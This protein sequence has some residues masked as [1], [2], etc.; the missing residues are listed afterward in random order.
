MRLND[1][2]AI[3]TGAGSGIGRAS[4]IL[5]AEEGARVVAADINQ[6]AGTQTV[7]QIKAQGGEAVMIQVDMTQTQEVAAM[8]NQAIERFGRIDI[9]YNHVGTYF[10]SSVV[11][12]EVEKWDF[13]LSLNLKSIFLGCKHT[14]PHMVKRKS[15]VIVNTGGTFGFYGGLGLAAYCASKGGVINLTK[16]MALDYGPYGIRINCVCPGFIDTPMNAHM[17]P[18]K[19]A[20]I[21]KMQPLGRAG[22]PEE[23]A[24][25][26]LFLASD[27]ASFFTGTTLL[28]DGGQL[29]G[30]HGA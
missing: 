15:G 1:K 30:R 18:E 20:A 12:L 7:E 25:A 8:V 4:A 6:E 28:V 21:I 27:D 13:A 2:I 16:Q 10:A 19:V 3:I 5:F 29:S 22:K 14:L 26:A 17:P 24:K 23:V 9:L 11:D